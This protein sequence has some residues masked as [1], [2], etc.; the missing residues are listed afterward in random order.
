MPCA[1]KLQHSSYLS[2]SLALQ[3]CEAKYSFTSNQ[4]IADVALEILSTVLQN[5]VMLFFPDVYMSFLLDLYTSL[6]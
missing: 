5:A 6:K 3:Y 1:T 4:A 2:I